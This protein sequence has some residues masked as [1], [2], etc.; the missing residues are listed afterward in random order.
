MMIIICRSFLVCLILFLYNIPCV[1]KNVFLW[2]MC[3]PFYAKCSFLIL[4]SLPVS[5]SYRLSMTCPGSWHRWESGY[6]D[7]R[8]I[9]CVLQNDV[10]EE[11]PLFA[12]L[13]LQWQERAPDSGGAGSVSEGGTKGTIR[14]WD[15]LFT[16]VLESGRLLVSRCTYMLHAG[17]TDE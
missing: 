11:R 13:E 4:N 15:G 14:L 8:R 12:A 6:P 2:F 7:I 9:L 10:F 17:Y 16:L 3:W 1:L 5:N